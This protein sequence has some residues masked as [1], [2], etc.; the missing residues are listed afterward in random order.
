MDIWC[1]LALAHICL[2]ELPL[3]NTI[4]NTCFS[5]KYPG[6]KGGGDYGPGPG[7]GPGPGSGSGGGAGGPFYHN[8]HH[9]LLAKTKATYLLRHRFPRLLSCSCSYFYSCSFPFYAYTAL[10]EANRCRT[11]RLRGES[12]G[13]IPLRSQRWCLLLFLA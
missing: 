11:H 9:Q 1:L 5:V 8:Q 6:W 13:C 3:E 12:R 7:P 2:G 4:R 10:L